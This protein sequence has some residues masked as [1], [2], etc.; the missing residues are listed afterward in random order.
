MSEN[1][2]HTGATL[3]SVALFNIPRHDLITKAAFQ[4]LNP[5]AKAKVEALLNLGDTQPD[6]WGGWA[7]RIKD[8]TPPTDTETKNFLK[9]AKNKSHKTWHYVNLPL[10]TTSYKAAETNGFTRPDDVVQMYKEC[11]KVLKN[12]QTEKRFSEVNALRLVGHLVGDIH[13]PLHIGCGFIDDATTPPTI[14]FDPKTILSKN[15]KKHHD[16]GGNK[17]LLPQSGNMHSFWDGSLSGPLNNIN[18]LAAGSHKELE[19]LLE[20]ITGAKKLT[21]NSGGTVGLAVT[22]L[23]DLAQKWAGESVKIS[24]TAYENIVMKA[25]NGAD[26]DVDFLTTKAD[27]IDKFRPV[28][29]K[30]MKFAAR[31]LADLLNAI[32]P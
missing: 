21:K 29:I 10:K 27:Y 7:D 16:T 1:N 2:K 14:V 17:I 23:E 6:N 20:I 31:R 26:Y 8:A 4:L 19:L 11:V 12:P 9:D 30:Q 22:P 25:K 24:R 18:L 5:T 15:L 3:F 32:Y 28:I 13:Q